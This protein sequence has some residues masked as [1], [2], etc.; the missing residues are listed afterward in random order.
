[1]NEYQIKKLELQAYGKNE[2]RRIARIEIEN[3][4]PQLQ[5]YIGKQINTQSGMSKKFV[6]TKL[7]PKPQPMPGG[8]ASLHVNSISTSYNSLVLK[9][10]ICLSGGKYE[11]KTYYC[12]YFDQT[13][14]IGE[15]NVFTLVKVCEFK[16]VANNGQLDDL[17]VV[18]EEVEKI[19]RFKQLEEEVRKLKYSIKL[20]F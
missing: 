4:L 10:S 6:I 8:F 1:M 18:N 14:Y 9:M 5:K 19:E 15:M 20:D 12:Q 13:F 3:V 7:D 17:I 16:E 2:L 11:D